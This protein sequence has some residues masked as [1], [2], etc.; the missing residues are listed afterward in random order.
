MIRHQSTH[1]AHDDKTVLFKKYT[2]GQYYAR[3]QAGG[4]GWDQGGRERSKR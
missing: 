4:E 3:T 1:I 2:A